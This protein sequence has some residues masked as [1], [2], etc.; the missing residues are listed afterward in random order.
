MLLPGI[1]SAITRFCHPHLR[2]RRL[3][4]DLSKSDQVGTPAAVWMFKQPWRSDGT[5]IQLTPVLLVNSSLQWIQGFPSHF[6]YD[7][8]RFSASPA[9]KSAFDAFLRMLV[10]FIISS[11]PTRVS[12][13]CIGGVEWTAVVLL[14]S[15]LNPRRIPS[16]LSL[17]SSSPILCMILYFRHPEL[18]IYL[19]HVSRPP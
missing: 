8:G 12:V 7:G 16:L 14:L 9:I 18:I 4:G 15:F 19:H 3:L 13:V 1:Y 6:N 10:S 11:I 17:V 5:T 2:K